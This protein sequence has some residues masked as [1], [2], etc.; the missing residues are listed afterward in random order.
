MHQQPYMDVQGLF[1]ST[2][3]SMD[4]QGLRLSTFV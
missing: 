4:V 1:L 3:S 2:I